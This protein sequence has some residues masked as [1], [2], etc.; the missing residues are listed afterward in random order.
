VCTIRIIRNY[1]GTLDSHVWVSPPKRLENDIIKVARFKLLIHLHLNMMNVKIHFQ[2]NFLSKR[3]QKRKRKLKHLKSLI[4][5]GS[6][7]KKENFINMWWE[8][9][10][11]G[12]LLPKIFVEIYMWFNL[13]ASNKKIFCTIIIL[14]YFKIKER[15]R[16]INRNVFIFVLFIFQARCS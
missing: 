3:K 1:C 9:V 2:N 8:R 13:T 11:V 5:F 6:K 10:S 14:Y 7:N 15:T 16:K 12:R 4:T